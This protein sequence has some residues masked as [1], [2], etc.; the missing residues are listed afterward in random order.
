VDGI[1][2]PFGRR[3]PNSIRYTSTSE[4]FHTGELEKRETRVLDI[5]KPQINLILTFVLVV[6]AAT[7]PE[8]RAFA[9]E[10]IESAF[11]AGKNWLL[12][13]TIGFK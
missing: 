8:A 13:G 5:A 1:R 7:I 12:K 4:A 6:M 3:E 11:D 9:I 2:K 10:K